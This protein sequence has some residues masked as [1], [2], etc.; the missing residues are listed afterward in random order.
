M[1]FKPTKLKIIL[2]ISLTVLLIFWFL[3]MDRGMMCKPC[4][5]N[6]KENCIDYGF[7]SAINPCYCG[8]LPLYK[9]LLSWLIIIIP[10]IIFYSI[11]S[12]FQKNSPIEQSEDRT[13]L[14]RVSG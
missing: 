6:L 1:N 3:M 10:V 7:I 4:P 14:Q 11:Y 8:C 9:A 13:A 2:T 5:M 12:L